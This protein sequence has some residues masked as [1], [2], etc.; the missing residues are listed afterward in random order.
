MS[1]KTTEAKSAGVPA[2]TPGSIVCYE[3][4]L[5][6]LNLAELPT[7]EPDPGEPDVRFG[8]R[9]VQTNA[10]S[11]PL[12]MAFMKV[13]ATSSRTVS[14]RRTGHREDGWRPEV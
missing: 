3:L 11:L 5:S 7:G 10:P 1:T 13:A 14:L 6:S 4:A 2:E 12:S 8:G 9:V